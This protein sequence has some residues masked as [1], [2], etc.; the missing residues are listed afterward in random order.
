MLLRLSGHNVSTAYDGPSALKT[1]R[2]NPPE[3]ILLDIGLPGMS[4]LDV[5]RHVRDDV[6]LKHVLLVAL[7]GYGQEED[8]QQT[9]MAGFDAHFVKPVE[10]DV[11]QKLLAERRGAGEKV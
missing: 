5:A 8:R 2:A 6:R 10:L 11:L 3:V 1:A 9:Q 7:T 4:G